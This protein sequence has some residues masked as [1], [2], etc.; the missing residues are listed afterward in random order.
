[1][2]SV[3]RL[4]RYAIPHRWRFGWAVAA[5]GVYAAASVALVALID[6]IFND[7]L[8]P[9]DADREP[10]QFW[11]IAATLLGNATVAELRNAIGSSSGSSRS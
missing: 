7:V 6:P 9:G 5:M 10:S 8:R 4:A 2:H 1:M 11:V 3:V